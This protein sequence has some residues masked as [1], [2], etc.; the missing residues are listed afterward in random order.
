MISRLHTFYFLKSTEKP[1]ASM[2]Q[3]NRLKSQLQGMV[4]I[5]GFY[6]TTQAFSSYHRNTPNASSFRFSPAIL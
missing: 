1:I 4:T 3:H 5:N 6:S 2:R